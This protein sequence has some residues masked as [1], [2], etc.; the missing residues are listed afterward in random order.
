VTRTASL[1]AS[2]KSYEKDQAALDARMELVKARYT[3]QFIA[4]DQLLTNLQST[5]SY[6]AQ[7]LQKSSG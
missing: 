5:G 7:Q 1:Q 3:K 4:M 2:K 6:L